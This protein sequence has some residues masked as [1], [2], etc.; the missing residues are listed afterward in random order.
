MQATYFFNIIE[1]VR[2]AGRILLPIGSIR[3]KNNR[4]I[5][6][7]HNT[8]SIYYLLGLL[9]PLVPDKRIIFGDSYVSANNHFCYLFGG[10]EYNDR[11]T[12]D[13]MQLF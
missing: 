2:D 5:I 1:N 4:R 10:A 9:S 6:E 13:K 11:T 3:S 8:N 7:L 12:N